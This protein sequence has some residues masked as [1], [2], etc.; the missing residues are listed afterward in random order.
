LLKERVSIWTQGKSYLWEFLWIMAYALRQRN[1]RLQDL[2]ALVFVCRTPILFLAGFVG[3]LATPFGVAL[4]RNRNDVKSVAYGAFKTHFT[5]LRD[6]AR[7]NLSKSFFANVVDVGANNGDFC[8]A[9]SAHSSKLVAI[10]ADPRNFRSLTSNILINR[11]MN[12][13]PVNVAAHDSESSVLLCGEGSAVR[14]VD[15]GQGQTVSGVP[16][17]AIVEKLLPGTIGILKID[18]QG[19]EEKVLAGMN[20]MLAGR[21]VLLLIIEL[22]P[23]WNGISLSRIESTLSRH[24]YDLVLEDKYL[25]GQPHVYFLART[26]AIGS[27]SIENPGVGPPQTPSLP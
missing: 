10:E 24:G 8:I 13:I 21:R 9:L 2:K 23:G 16:L 20:R 4:V 5:Y 26:L 22:H 17:D 15:S 11:A 1:R 27:I 14:V 7:L 6:L 25:F 12:I 18:V 19:H 3:P